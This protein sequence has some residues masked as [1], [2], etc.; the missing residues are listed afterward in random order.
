LV[1][2]YPLVA[3][4]ALDRGMSEQRAAIRMCWVWGLTNGILAMG[5][6]TCIWLVRNPVIAAASFVGFCALLGNSLRYYR[7]LEQLRNENN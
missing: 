1:Y 7:R 5:A 2:R 4:E 6:L 3:N